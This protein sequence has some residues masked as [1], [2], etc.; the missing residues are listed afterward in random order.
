MIPECSTRV[1]AAIFQ[2]LGIQ[3]A[4]GR[5]AEQLD[6][7]FCAVKDRPAMLNQKVPSLVFDQGFFQ[8]NLPAFDVGE[9]LLEFRQG[10]FEVLRRR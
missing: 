5:L 10:G 1:F 8:P 4:I 9:D 7:F 3:F 6:L 2:R